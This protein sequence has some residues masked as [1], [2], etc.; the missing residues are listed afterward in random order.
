MCTAL[1]IAMRTVYPLG[2]YLDV[3]R[4]WRMI[5]SKNRSFCTSHRHDLKI[6]FQQPDEHACNTSHTDSMEKNSLVERQD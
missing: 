5:L 6:V 4:R 3:E 1:N 2:K